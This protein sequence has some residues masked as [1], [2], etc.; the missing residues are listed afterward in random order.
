MNWLDLV[1]QEA[2]KTGHVIT[3]EAAD[4]ILWEHTGFPSFYLGDDPVEYFTNQLRD[5]F[6]GKLHCCCCGCDLVGDGR[7]IGARLCGEC[8]VNLTKE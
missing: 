2:S 5:F 6:A 7:T 1:H 3:D 4:A 8:L